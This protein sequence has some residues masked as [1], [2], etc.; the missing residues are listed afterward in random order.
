MPAPRNRNAPQKPQTA[1]QP[2]GRPAV[3]T[4]RDLDA[5][6]DGG[7]GQPNLGRGADEEGGGQGAPQGGEGGEGEEPVEGDGQGAEEEEVNGQVG[8]QGQARAGPEAEA[9]AFDALGRLIGV[10]TATLR[11]ALIHA[12]AR[13]GQD[14][15]QENAGAAARERE[16]RN[17][18]LA[19][20]V[21]DPSDNAEQGELDDLL[22][23]RVTEHA[24]PW[25]APAS[26]PST[27]LEAGNARDPGAM[28]A[29]EAAKA[30]SQDLLSPMDFAE[31]E[32]TMFQEE[33]LQPDNRIITSKSILCAVPL[34][35]LTTKANIGVRDQT[36]KIK[37]NKV[38]I[39][40]G[41]TRRSRMRTLSRRRSGEAGT[42]TSS[43]RSCRGWSHSLHVMS[44]Y[45]EHA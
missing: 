35:A 16:R 40:T 32:A 37:Y 26:W 8:G 25:M 5:F 18:L 6:Q 14:A 39:R 24:G 4:G 45:A 1:G 15:G 13:A 23:E 44:E 38:T 2:S 7:G 20:A 29:P 28:S 3:A 41:E 11:A 34:T 9:E 19:R 36:I 17:E 30:L 12:G 31:G 22:R 33:G 21:N 27:A 10:D 42:R 43:I